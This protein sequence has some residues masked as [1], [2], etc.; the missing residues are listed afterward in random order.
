MPFKVVL[1]AFVFETK[2]GAEAVQ[3]L[4]TDALMNAT[5][6]DT[7]AAVARIVEVEADPE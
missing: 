1:E 7:I 6:A 2:E 4:L 5:G 3:D